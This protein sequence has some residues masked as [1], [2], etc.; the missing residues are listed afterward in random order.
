MLRSCVAFLDRTLAEA[1]VSHA[2]LELLARETGPMLLRLT[3]HATRARLAALHRAVEAEL[4]L[5]S[6][7]ERRALQV[8]IAGDHQARVRSLAVQ[9]FQ[10]RFDELP[11]ADRRVTYAE[12][13]DEPALA[14]GLVGKRI[15]DRDIAVAFF[16]DP[17]RLQ[18]DV[19]GD[20][21][22]L[23]LDQ[24]RLERIE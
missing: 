22:A 18:R 11:G 9:Y 10:R 6:G 2:A 12:G 19:L 15:L 17:A 3:E 16:G 7:Q 5:M 8:V 1:C 21:A 23:L 13:L 20:A 24:A 14:L 4:A